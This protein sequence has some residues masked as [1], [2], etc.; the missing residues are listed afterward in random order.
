MDPSLHGAACN[1]HLGKVNRLKARIA[2]AETVEPDSPIAEAQKLN[3]KLQSLF[4]SKKAE[5]ERGDKWDS[6]AAYLE[7]QALAARAH[8]RVCRKNAE[9]IQADVQ[10]VSQQLAV[11]TSGA[12]P[13]AVSVEAPDNAKSAEEERHRELQQQFEEA[14]RHQQEQIMAEVAVMRGQWQAQLLAAQG[15]TPTTTGEA[16]SSAAAPPQEAPEITKMGE[17]FKKKSA[18]IASK[19]ATSVIKGS[20]C[21]EKDKDKKKAAKLEGKAAEAAAEAERLASQVEVGLAG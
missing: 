4:S 16:G 21:K 7:K 13:A 1:Q 6:K 17:S 19:A 18:A 14:L 5:N 3:S 20:I 11:L 15:S 10:S 2:A 9:D 12:P 8:A